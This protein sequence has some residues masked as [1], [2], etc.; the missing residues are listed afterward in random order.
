VLFVV[1]PSCSPIPSSSRE[2]LL[3]VFAKPDALI[4]A[5]GDR[6]AQLEAGLGK[7]SRK[8]SSSDGLAKPAPK[9]LRRLSGCKPGKQQGGQGVRLDLEQSPMRS[10]LMPRPPAGGAEQTLLTLRWWR[11]TRQVLDLPAI[12][13]VAIEHRAATRVPGRGGDRAPFPAEATATSCYGP[14]VA[15]LA[16]HLLG[17][18]HLPTEL[19]AECLEEAFGAGVSSVK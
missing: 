19:A 6:V 3:V 8:P 13:L 15:A 2:Q 7:F 9:S 11:P 10:V 17:R 5:L 18:Q 12:D 4:V 1:D 14:G 16:S